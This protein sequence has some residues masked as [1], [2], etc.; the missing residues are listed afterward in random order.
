MMRFISLKDFLPEELLI[1]TMI[2]TSRIG[3]IVIGSEK[4]FGT[5]KQEAMLMTF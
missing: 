3:N 1:A 4:F 5:S 2:T